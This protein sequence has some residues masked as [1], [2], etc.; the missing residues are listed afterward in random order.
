VEQPEHEKSPAF[1][2][3]LEEKPNRQTLSFDVIE[4]E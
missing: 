1:V 4:F 2:Y 3:T